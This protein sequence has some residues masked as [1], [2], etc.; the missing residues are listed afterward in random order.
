MNLEKYSN[1]LEKDITKIVIEVLGKILK[2]VNTKLFVKYENFFKTYYWRDYVKKPTSVYFLKWIEKN[3]RG[4]YQSGYKYNIPSLTN[5]PKLEHV[6][7]PVICRSGFHCSDDN[8]IMIWNGINSILYVV[9]AYGDFD[10]DENLNKISFSDIKVIEEVGYMFDNELIIKKPISYKIENI[11]EY[12]TNNS[13][14]VERMSKLDVRDN[15]NI[16]KHI[17]VD[18]LIDEFEKSTI[19]NCNLDMLIRNVLSLNVRPNCEK[20]INYILLNESKFSISLNNKMVINSL[21]KT[22]KKMEEKENTQID[23]TAAKK[24][25]TVKIDKYTGKPK[26]ARTKKK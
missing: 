16:L 2:K 18:M 17:T 11:E 25:P 15:S 12:V 5:S 19:I 21:K 10:F 13:T 7:K 4:R 8:D 1:I 6:N 22:Q 3:G 14:N 26:K 9:E 24:A 20:I 23:K